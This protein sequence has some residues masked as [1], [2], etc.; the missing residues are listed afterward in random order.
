MVRPWGLGKGS[1]L[2][3]LKRHKDS[4][5]CVAFSADSKWLASGSM[6]GTVRLWNPAT[7]LALQILQAYEELIWS[8]AFSAD[9]KQLA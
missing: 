7:G 8:V 6:D 1:V 3:T 4:I 9:S 2:Q 5:W